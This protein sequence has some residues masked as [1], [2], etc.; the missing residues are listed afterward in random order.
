MKENSTQKQQ[1]NSKGSLAML[2]RHT[3]QIYAASCINFR[4]L[5]IVSRTSAFH[6]LVI[7]FRGVKLWFV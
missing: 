3:E 2:Q 1:N 6:G 5:P 7:S 4:T